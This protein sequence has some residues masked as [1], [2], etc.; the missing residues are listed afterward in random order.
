MTSFRKKLAACLTVCM[1][2]TNLLPAM[3]ETQ[4]TVSYEDAGI[5][6]ETV[7]VEVTA[8]EIEE[9]VEV[10][11]DREE[12]AASGEASDVKMLSAGTEEVQYIDRVWNGN[13]AT[14][15]EATKK[16]TDYKLISSDTAAITS[17]EAGVWYVVQGT[18]KISERIVNNGTVANPARLILTD[19]CSLQAEWGIQNKK[20]NSLIIY[21]QTAGTGTLAAVKSSAIESAVV[22][23]GIDSLGYGMSGI[24]GN[25]YEDG[26]NLTIN[27]GTVHSTAGYGGAAIGGGGS[28]HGGTITI[29]GGT[30][31]AE[32][33]VHLEGAGIGGGFMGSGG[34]IT[35]NGGKVTAT[36]GYDGAAIGGGDNGYA[37]I[38]TINGGEIDARSLATRGTGIGAS[39]KYNSNGQSTDTNCDITINGGTI[40]AYGGKEGNG[41]YGA[42]VTIN[43]GEVAAYGYDSS[44]ID[45]DTEPG[46]TANIDSY[47]TCRLGI[48]GNTGVTITGGTV[49]AIATGDTYDSIINAAINASSDV[50]I[51]G[52]ETAVS[53][54]G[55]GEMTLGITS[56]GT[57]TIDGGEI[58]VQ[59]K[60]GDGIKGYPVTINDGS[61]ESYSEIGSAVGGTGFQTK[62]QNVQIIAG[63]S[64]ST[65]VYMTPLEYVSKDIADRHYLRTQSNPTYTVK[66]LVQKADGDGYEER[67]TETLKGYA[68]QLTSASVKSYE[69]VTAQPFAQ[70][71]IQSDSGTVV[72]IY[73][74]RISYTIFFDTN[75]YGKTPEPITAFYGAA[76]SEPAAPKA[77]G[78]TFGGWFEDED[79]TTQYTFS[80]MPSGGKILYA[81]WT[82]NDK[83]QYTV[84]WKLDSATVIDTEKVTEGDMPS[85]EDASKDGYIFIG[86]DPALSPVT[87]DITYTAKFIQKSADQVA[88]KFNTNG[89]SYIDTQ[90]IKKGE[91]AEQ[92]ANPTKEGYTFIGWYTDE[93][94]GTAFDFTK[95]VSADTTVYAKWIQGTK[96]TYTILWKD[97]DGKELARITAE[98]GGLP[99]YP[100]AKPTRSGYIFTGWDK[101]IAL[102]AAD[103]TY[104]ATYEKKSS[105]GGGGGGGVTVVSGSQ[106]TGVTFSQ[107]WY[108]DS[109][110]V[111]RIKNNAG[112]VVANAWLCDDA[113]MANGQNVWYLL[114][115]DGA[116]IGAGLVQ[117]NTGN[118]Y[119]LET[120]HNGYFGMLRYINGYYNCNGQSVYLTFNREHNG[121]FGAI[122]NAEGLEKLKA[123][124]GVT[125][126]G[127]GNE[128]AVY[129][130]GF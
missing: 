64:E 53:A 65:A 4:N 69:E 2:V 121:S 68:G 88:V 77:D 54:T 127:I 130:A 110:G 29:N 19:G 37:G 80:T 18:V 85:H 48:G 22:N 14:V 59:T 31:I 115:G 70:K 104:T 49:E 36:T 113:V 15:S 76:V 3:A 103:T 108:Q 32:G 125:Q 56:N 74:D 12:A 26:G 46:D 128:N 52:D 25:R 93:S 42:N 60:D 38:I 119:S 47:Y 98:E 114:T 10:I 91:K 8:A 63:A 118:Y 86:W 7:G 124:Y 30:V 13:E 50:S 33:N 126:Y 82:K 90:V 102:A 57:V 5:F 43:G 9:V 120:E 73:Y 51:S 24:G 106:K 116:M 84:T 1:V 21:G 83:P 112:Q 72:E 95:S 28:N 20:G 58:S 81:K 44:L 107:N 55:N 100:N 35:I 117:D 61:I 66:H 123:I 11:K 96:K 87:A 78:Y 109:Y 27:G 6:A 97:Y 105:G 67:E 16:I 62:E 79:C 17:F 39:I 89:G 75:G 45:E 94:Y 41:I 23:S 111:W 101:D 40:K 92:P 71:T 99:K 34:T 122:T 129:T